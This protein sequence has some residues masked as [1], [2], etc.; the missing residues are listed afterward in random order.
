MDS[1][2]ERG[3]G[4]EDFFALQQEHQFKVIA[5][6]NQK[7]GEWAAD[8]L[9]I[10]ESQRPEYIKSV[11]LADLEEVGDQDVIRKLKKD[12]DDANKDVSEDEIIEK[13]GVFFGESRKEVLSPD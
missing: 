9:G 1:F 6:R 2:K 3:K 11:K 7:I 8:I 13:L 10:A 12:F 4:E 5:R